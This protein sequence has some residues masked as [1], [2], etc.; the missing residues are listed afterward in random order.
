[1]SL[2]LQVLPKIRSGGENEEK[3]TKILNEYATSRY[4]YDFLRVFLG[5]RTV[6]IGTIANV[7]ENAGGGVV[8]DFGNTPEGNA[9]IM[10]KYNEI[11]C[12]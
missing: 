4:N 3:L 5:V 11:I 10:V 1:M 2:C 12:E 8:V 7:L 6:E 9:C